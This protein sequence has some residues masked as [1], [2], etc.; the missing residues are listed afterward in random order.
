MSISSIISSAGFRSSGSLMLGINPHTSGNSIKSALEANAGSGNVTIMNANNQ[1]ITDNAVGTGSK[2]TIK[3][4]AG[5]ETFTIV[6]K[7]DTSGDG[8]INALDLL[9]IQKSILGTYSLKDSYKTAGD[10]SS[11]NTIN[12]LDLLQIQ[13][14][15]LGTY[16]IRQ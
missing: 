15:I 7:G 13:K 2:V 8:V 16:D 14:N 9:Q 4:S 11:D 5:T 1:T 10:T 12:A 6:I 3:T